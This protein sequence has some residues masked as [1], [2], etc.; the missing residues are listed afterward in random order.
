[1]FLKSPKSKSQKARAKTLR[2]MRD[3]RDPLAERR[4]DICDQKG[5]LEDGTPKHKGC[6]RNPDGTLRVKKGKGRKARRGRKSGRRTRR[7]RRVR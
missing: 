1:M 6:R 5:L 2:T 3:R 4:L 7:T